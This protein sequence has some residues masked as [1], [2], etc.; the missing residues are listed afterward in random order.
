LSIT[1]DRYAHAGSA[2]VEIE[3]T[4]EGFR[5]RWKATDS[6]GTEIAEESKTILFTT[7][8]NPAKPHPYLEQYIRTNIQKTRLKRKNRLKVAEWSWSER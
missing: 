1:G 2:L 8:D 3:K 5:F 4:A 6:E 7:I